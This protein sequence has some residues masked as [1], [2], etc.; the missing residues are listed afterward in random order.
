MLTKGMDSQVRAMLER[1]VDAMIRQ[2]DY[3]SEKGHKNVA[4][5]KKVGWGRPRLAVVCWLNSFYQIVISP[6]AASA[7][8][9]SQADLGGAVPILYG[10]KIKFTWSR[11]RKIK[12]MTV[13]FLGICTS[14]NVSQYM[15]S[16]HHMDDLLYIIAKNAS[17]S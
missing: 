9:N 14:L 6:L 2:F 5:A 1:R 16:A 17:E 3:L 8:A 4:T 11:R 7:E 13:S 15:L 12:T 10:D